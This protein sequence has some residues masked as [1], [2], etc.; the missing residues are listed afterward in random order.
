M[1]SLLATPPALEKFRQ[2]ISWNNLPVASI[3]KHLAICIEEDLGEIPES[4]LL[5]R[6]ITT[7]AA[8]IKNT[9]TA[10][11]V[12]REPT[13]ICG[14]K[15]IPVIAE[16][17]GTE[18]VKLHTHHMDGDLVEG[19]QVVAELTGPENEILLLERC[20]LNFLQRLSGIAT[21]TYSFVQKIENYNVG[22]LDTRKTTPG[23]RNLEKYATACGG[24]YNHRMGLHDRIL[25]KDNHLAATGCSSGFKLKSFLAEIVKTK[26]PKMIVEVEIDK[27]EQFL[28]AL[29]SGVDAILLDNFSPKEINEVVQKNEGRVVLEASGGIAES[30]LTDYAEAKPHFIS[31][32]APIHSSR[33]VDIGLDWN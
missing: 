18:K 17:F 33:W 9:G 20:V 13:V 8:G 6:D 7:R 27:L 5:E 10:R 15:L 14:L 22:L 16:A 23:L 19:N 2:R 21:K 12:V 24:S 11:I 32:G 3:L 25:I 29:E 31:T 30:T 26:D 28:P 1:A 4:N